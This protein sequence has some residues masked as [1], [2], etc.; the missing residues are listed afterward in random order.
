MHDDATVRYLAANDE[1]RNVKGWLQ[2]LYIE[3]FQVDLVT[4]V[5]CSDTLLRIHATAEEYEATAENALTP[6]QVSK[7]HFQHLQSWSS[8]TYA[9]LELFKSVS[10]CQQL[11][12]LYSTSAPVNGHQLPRSKACLYR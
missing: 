4:P 1:P 5:A 11:F 12:T 2:Q 6:I 9:K 3:C 10:W 7:S 8:S